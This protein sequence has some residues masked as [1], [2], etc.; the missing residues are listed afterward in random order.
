M[1][2]WGDG[3][4]GDG[5]KSEKYYFCGGYKQVTSNPKRQK[6][7]EK[8]M[9][10]KPAEHFEHLVLPDNKANASKN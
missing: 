1:G 2:G 3:E 4:M 8:Q 10:K 5:K 9:I 7:N 6:Y